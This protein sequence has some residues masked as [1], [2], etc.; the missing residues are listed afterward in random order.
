MEE[1][2]VWNSRAIGKE[3]GGAGGGAG[4]QAQPRDLQL[5]LCVNVLLG[6][7][8]VGM[9]VS[10]AALGLPPAPILQ[11]HVCCNPLPA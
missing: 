6:L 3:K 4:D 10:P 5:L 7:R 11:A 8:A 1:T 9:S 2:L